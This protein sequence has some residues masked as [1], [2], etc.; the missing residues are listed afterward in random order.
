MGTR[1]KSN[2]TLFSGVPFDATY[3]NVL[4]F[5]SQKDLDAYLKRYAMGS[6]SQAGAYQ[7][8]NR[9]I[10][11]ATDD[12]TTTNELLNY[13]YARIEN[14][15]SAGKVHRV[16]YAFLTNFEYENDGLTYIYFS[17]DQW[18]TYRNRVSFGNAYIDRGF[19]KEYTTPG[20]FTPKFAAIKNNG[21]DIGGDGAT[22]LRSSAGI[23]FNKKTD[24]AGALHVDDT[25]VKFLL[26]TTQPQ[27]AKNNRGS[28]LGIYSQYLYYILAYNPNTNLCYSV[29]KGKDLVTD[30]D[31]MSIN[32]AYQALATD[33]VLVGSGSLVVDSEVYSYIGLPFH[34]SASGKSVVFEDVNIYLTAGTK[35]QPLTRI[36][37]AGVASFKPQN[38]IG[39][40]AAYN[41][42]DLAGTLAEQLQRIMDQITGVTNSPVKL[43]G[44][45]FSKIYLT[46]GKGA[47]G[48]FDALK[49]TSLTATGPRVRRHAGITNN[50]HEVYIMSDYN[51][52]PTKDTTLPVAGENAMVV[53]DSARDTPILADSYTEFLNANRNQINN[54][55]ANAKMNKVLAQQGNALT[56]A[57]T[58]RG[59]NTQAA[60][61]QY[62][63]GRAYGSNAI[64]AINGGVRG[65]IGGLATGGLLGAGIGLASAG[66]GLAT[67][68]L[69]TSYNNTT[70]MTAGNM[71]RAT[72]MENARA[73][74]AYN[75]AVATNNYEQ[76]L[77]SQNA[78]LADV[79]NHNA[80][81][82]H[83][84]SNMAGDYQMG[85]REMHWQFFTSQTAIL[86][87]ACLYFL[88]FGYSVQQYDKLDDYL[89]VK[90]NFSYV[91]TRNLNTQGPVN[92]A[93]INFFNDVFNNGVT[94]WESSA[95]EK[96]NT[97]D[98]SGNVFK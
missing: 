9:A 51:A 25:Q 1:T 84:G 37:F 36:W 32:D 77:R 35:T 6:I 30:I 2:I 45:P 70:A 8:L 81:V 66:F 91:K 90:T 10:K 89:H 46:N 58:S 23:D 42:V 29:Y 82:A 69:A 61:Q 22:T 55:R 38:G 17:I 86:K 68:D 59:V 53:D 94:L 27:D 50:G 11:W 31:D 75:N 56:L 26:F 64:G 44:E 7:P 98:I 16:Y 92:Q 3:K 13:N 74:Y 87:N 57:N 41:N 39:H 95:A 80:D 40:N 12:T 79:K 83:E 63:Q 78:Q 93:V 15:G 65:V 54:V 88:L 47:E 52:D 43:I 34:L 14:W 19:V 24:A 73:N 96:F 28:N 20:I 4:N 62:T 5:A 72:T 76:T 48:D 49:F 67:S 71:S 97:R 85:N 18:Q 21:E 60:V 33:P